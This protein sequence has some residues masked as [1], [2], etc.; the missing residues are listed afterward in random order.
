MEPINKIKNKK[1]AWYYKKKFKKME[2]ERS[3]EM[4]ALQKEN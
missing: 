2:K 3:D 4:E 1:G